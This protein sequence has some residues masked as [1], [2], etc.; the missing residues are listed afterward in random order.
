[1]LSETERLRQQMARQAAIER[2][3]AR[4]RQAIGARLSHASRQEDTRR[5]ILAGAWA[6]RR[7]EASAEF[8][9]MMLGDL[10]RIW[11]TRDDDRALFGLPPLTPEEKAAREAKP[12]KASPPKPDG[13]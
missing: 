6:L 9:A 3:A 7:A 4:K 13:K 2:E 10:D 11:L 5:K 1:M 12:G 8:S